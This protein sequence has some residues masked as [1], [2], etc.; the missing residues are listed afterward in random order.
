MPINLQNLIDTSNLLELFN[1][2][3]VFHPKNMFDFSYS[4]TRLAEGPL[5][6]E[7]DG[8]TYTFYYRLCTVEI[9]GSHNIVPSWKIEVREG[10]EDHNSGFEQF[11]I[12]ILHNGV[13]VAGQVVMEDY[14]VDGIRGKGIPENAMLTWLA[15]VGLPLF[16]S[17]PLDR[18]DHV[19]VYEGEGRIPQA[20]KVWDRLMNL[21]ALRDDIKVKKYPNIGLY[22]LMTADVDD[23]MIHMLKINYRLPN[24]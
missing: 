12:P 7:R 1:R 14:R 22:V 23:T 20:T 8:Q 2:N 3:F 9:I 11:V 13:C 5:L 18:P 19:K 4:I 15:H 10:S 24:F 17:V 21:S 16:S 6:T